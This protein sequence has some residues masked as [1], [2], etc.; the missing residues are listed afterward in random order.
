VHTFFCGC[1]VLI[2]EGFRRSFSVI[3]DWFVE[4]VKMVSF[5]DLFA[6]RFGDERR[7]KRVSSGRTA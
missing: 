1:V 2:L 6:G 4:G 5:M 7:A 3:W